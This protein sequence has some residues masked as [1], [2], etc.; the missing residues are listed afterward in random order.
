MSGAGTGPS[1]SALLRDCSELA[2]AVAIARQTMVGGGHAD[3]DA[4]AERLREVLD[5]IAALP[6]AEQQALLPQLIALAEEI[7]AL[8]GTIAAECRRC[9]EELAKGEVSARVA[10]AY[11]KTSLN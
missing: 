8:G 4:L 10:A 5:G 7:D 9:A 3:L 1:A 11:A 6:R 2:T